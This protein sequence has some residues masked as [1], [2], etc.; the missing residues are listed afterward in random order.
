MTKPVLY[1]IVMVLVTNRYKMIGK[2]V[3]TMALI[4]QGAI[5]IIEREV[6]K[7]IQEQIQKRCPTNKPQS[8]QQFHEICIYED[9]LRIV[10]RA[11]NTA[12]YNPS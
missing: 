9:A 2:G 10:K 12:Y 6:N 3:N 1:D 4:S 11:L 5:E 8:E 7:G